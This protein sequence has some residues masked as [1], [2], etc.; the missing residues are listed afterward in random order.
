MLPSIGV[1]L[2]ALA[3]SLASEAHAAPRVFVASFGDDGHPCTLVQP[4]RTF[5]KA[6]SAV[7]AYGEVIVLDSAAYG[8]VYIAKSVALIAPPGIHASITGNPY[9]NLDSAVYIDGD[10][11]RV[12]LRGIRIN[13]GS[14][15]GVYFNRG[16]LLEVDDCV[17]TGTGQQ[18]ITLAP[19]NSEA[20]I[21]DT[22]LSDN[23]NAGINTGHATAFLN[24]VRIESNSFGISVGD[25]GVVT[26]RDSLI[27]R[28][29][30]DGLDVTSGGAN[31]TFERTT[32]SDNGFIGGISILGVFNQ[33]TTV[34]LVSSVLERNLLAMFAYPPAQARVALVNSTVANDATAVVM[35]GPGTTLSFKGSTIHSTSGTGIQSYSGGPVYTSVD[36]RID[37]PTPVDQVFFVNQPWY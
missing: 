6:V 31:V 13:G 5:A 34:R 37:A 4:C 12:S 3:L 9:V 16:A 19:A 14:S 22:S 36:N 20:V 1:V 7:D 10:S 26:I 15:W 33:V 24:R 8:P 11:I 21:S 27:A 2:A 17:I 30:I 32:I 23:I 29:T 25:T 35:Q 28:N 18:A